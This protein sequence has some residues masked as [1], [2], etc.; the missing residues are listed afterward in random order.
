MEIEIALKQLGLTP[1][2]ISVYQNTLK[3]GISKASEIAVKSNVKR[4]ACYYTLSLL[5]EKGLASEVIKSG[6]KYYS[7][8]PPERLLEIIKEE[9]NKK[10]SMIKEVL[11]DLKE[12]HSTALKKPKIEFFEGPEGFKTITSLLLKESNSEILGYVPSKIMPYFPTLGSQFRRQRKERNI[13]I[14]AIADF[15][16]MMK[17]FHKNDKEELRKIKINDLIVKN[18]DSAIYI[19]PNSLIILKANEKEKVGFLIEDKSITKMQKQIFEQ[20]WKLSKTL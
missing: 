17:E 7:A 5:I 16:E 13:S 12:L 18:M 15:S 11:P 4:S 3:L 6:V 14:R 9:A 20:I 10:S 1:Q 8:A 19:L 2:E